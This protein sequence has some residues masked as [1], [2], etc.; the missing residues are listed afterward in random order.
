MCT[1]DFI[2][3]PNKRLREIRVEIM[4]DIE[5]MRYLMDMSVYDLIKLHIELRRELGDKLIELRHQSRLY[6]LARQVD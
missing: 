4:E 2:F 1:D 6:D 5:Y 3:D